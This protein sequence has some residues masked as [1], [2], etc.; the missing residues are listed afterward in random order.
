MT[1]PSAPS[2]PKRRRAV[3]WMVVGMVFGFGT[4]VAFLWRMD[5][6]MTMVGQTFPNS[7]FDYVVS[8]S[9]I[10]GMLI[11]GLFV[12][13]NIYG[14]S[15]FIDFFPAIILNALFYGLVGFLLMRLKD[16]MWPAPPSE[17]EPAS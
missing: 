14:S 4:T 16:R 10:P 2:N 1:T 12:R 7:I 13:A 3:V 8:I 6:S 17:I 5:N 15:L 11:T 9:S